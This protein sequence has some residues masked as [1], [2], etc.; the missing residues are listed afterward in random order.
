MNL[1]G[2]LVPGDYCS[3]EIPCLLIGFGGHKLGF[4][5]DH[6][7]LEARAGSPQKGRCSMKSRLKPS[8]P[9]QG[10]SQE[11]G[12]VGRVGPLQFGLDNITAHLKSICCFFRRERWYLGRASLC[13]KGQRSLKQKTKL[14]CCQIPTK[15]FS[16]PQTNAAV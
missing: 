5:G 8:P 7:Q 10:L 4:P 1:R 12:E 11:V 14:F 15:S 3:S 6:L 9:R 2:R 16:C 13:V